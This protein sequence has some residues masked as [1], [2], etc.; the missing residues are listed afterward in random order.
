MRFVP[1]LL[2]PILGALLGALA[3]V[4]IASAPPAQAQGGPSLIRDTEVER[5]VRVY[6]DPLLLA[7]GLSPDAVRLFIVNEQSINAFVAEG[8]NMFIHTGL[9]M[10][11][12]TPE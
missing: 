8:Q 10:A 9:I 4:W 12:D 11:L 3:I 7:A 2:R 6:L 5:V 1:P